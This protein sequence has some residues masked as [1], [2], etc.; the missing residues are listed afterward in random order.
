MI[1]LV[2]PAVIYPAAHLFIPVW[3]PLS[4]PLC[5]GKDTNLYHGILLYRSLIQT[6][7][8]YVALVFLYTRITSLSCF[9]QRH[10][11]MLPAS[12]ASDVG[13]LIGATVTLVQHA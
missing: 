2:L 5:N 3:R 11:G 7:S 9:P 6:P 1:D 12:L 4:A 10:A 8:L 13:I